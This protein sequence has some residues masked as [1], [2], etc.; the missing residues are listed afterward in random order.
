MK[1]AIPAAEQSPAARLAAVPPAADSST[2]AAAEP[3]PRNTPEMG[4]EAR[5]RATKPARRSWRSSST[6]TVLSITFGE[7]F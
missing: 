1:R 7:D 5:Q 2:H 4:N 3:E 6:H